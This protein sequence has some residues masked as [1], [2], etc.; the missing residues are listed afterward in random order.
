[1]SLFTLK[2]ILRRSNG[3]SG[4]NPDMMMMIEKVGSRN[5]Q[6]SITVLKT[7]PSRVGKIV[8]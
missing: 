7:P 4:K 5:I 8:L 1:M 3:P 2:M 6:G